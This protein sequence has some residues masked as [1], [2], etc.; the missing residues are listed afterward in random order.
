[1]GD[2]G[3]VGFSVAAAAISWV[4]YARLQERPL[5]FW[6]SRHAELIL[7]A[8][9]ARAFR[10]APATVADQAAVNA[11]ADRTITLGGRLFALSDERD[12]SHANGFSHIRNGLIHDRSF[13]WDEEACAAPPRWTMRSSSWK[14]TSASSWRWRS[15]AR[16]RA[17]VDADRTASIRPMAVVLEDFLR[18]QFP[19]AAAA[20]PSR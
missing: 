11:G 7:R 12:V 5:A 8:P 1:M 3:I 19:P 4:Y 6:G 10:L 20:E 18:E 15:T 9:T 2:P 13:A 17:L 16:A 14:E